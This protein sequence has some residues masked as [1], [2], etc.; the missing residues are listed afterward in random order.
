MPADTIRLTPKDRKAWRSWLQKY[1]TKEAAVCLIFYKKGSGKSNISYNDAVEEALCFG[2][3]DSIVQPIDE[4][5]YMQRFTPRKVKSVWSAINK[6]R[7]EQMIAQNLMMPAGM[8][9]IDVGKKNGSWTKLDDV[10]RHV[11]PPELSTLFA[12]NKKV[13]RYFESLSKSNQKI[14]LY[15]LNS[16]K[17]AETK[18]KRIKELVAAANEVG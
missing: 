16:A 15:R 2:W 13:F 12:K 17:L 3:I 14:W 1:G 18:A 11:I 4:E 7:V 5:K 8:E 9:I 10:E 6:K